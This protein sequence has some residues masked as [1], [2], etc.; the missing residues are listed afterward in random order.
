[1]AKDAPKRGKFI[2]FELANHWFA[3]P[4]AA[5]LRIVNCPPSN[6]G[7]TISVGVV[8]LGPHTIRLLD[9]QTQWGLQPEAHSPEETP[10]LL[11]VRGP[12][13]ALWGIAL[14]TPPDLLELP[15]SRFKPVPPE[16]RLALKLQ[17]ISHMAVIAEQDIHCTLLLLDLKAMFQN[18]TMA[19]AS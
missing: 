8:Q 13:Q 18:K 7:G 11:V 3:L 16:K 19:V 2:A 9:L 12:Q 14:D 1:M 17:W 4:M 6:Q 10:F 15:L 5:V